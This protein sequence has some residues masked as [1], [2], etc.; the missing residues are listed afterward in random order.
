MRAT[1]SNKLH[2]TKQALLACHIDSYRPATCTAQCGWAPAGV[3]Q[4]SYSAKYPAPGSRQ[5]DDG[6]VRCD[7]YGLD[8]ES[9]CRIWVTCHRFFW[10]V[11]RKMN[12]PP[13]SRTLRG[14]SVPPQ[15]PVLLYAQRHTCCR[16]SWPNRFG[17]VQHATRL[18]DGVW[19]VTLVT[20]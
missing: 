11:D 12:F 17:R 5:S 20:S 1:L 16:L 7:L 14:G 6:G 15:Q 13:K 18:P 2:M 4:R 9:E 10:L 3:H 19:V 8:F